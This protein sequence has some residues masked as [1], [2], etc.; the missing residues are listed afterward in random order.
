MSNN[1]KALRLLLIA[2]AVG[3]VVSVVWAIVVLN[4][5][6]PP[7][8]TRLQEHDAETLV[9]SWCNGYTDKTEDECYAWAAEMMDDHRDEIMACRY[10]DARTQ[11]DC[12]DSLGLEP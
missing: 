8:V 10:A 9:V 12:I 7:I 4:Q 1:N 2:I 11:F 5:E 6:P 3:L